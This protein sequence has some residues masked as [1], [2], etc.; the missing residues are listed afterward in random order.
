[1]EATA[2]AEGFCKAL[3]NQKRGPSHGEG[4]QGW[5]VALDANVIRLRETQ[6]AKD[7]ASKCDSESVEKSPTLQIV[8]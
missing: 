2:I 4:T 5:G 8:D 3:K 7:A 6:A 1:M